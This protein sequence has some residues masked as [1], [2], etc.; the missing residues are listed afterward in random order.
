MEEFYT[1]QGEG[2]HTGK[3]AYFLRIGGCDVGC[4]W[5]DTKESWNAALYP[6]VP[7]EDIVQKI[8]AM[9]IGAV[10]VTG[11]EP[12][13]YNLSV[14]TAEL[15]KAGIR[16]FVETSGSRPVSGDWD[17]ICLSP[18]RKFPPVNELY[19]LASELKM[20]IAGEEDFTWAEINAGFVNARCHLFL[21][22][23]WSVREKMI[24]QIIRYIKEYPKWGLS[25]QTHKYLGIP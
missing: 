21:Q 1:L 11:G 13:L 20:I 7:V 15:K 8:T 14:L 24:P 25:L 22:P 3:A 4:Y 6:P 2:F 5:C 12:L 18:K 19:S 9:K 17:W 10:V 23:E 16:T